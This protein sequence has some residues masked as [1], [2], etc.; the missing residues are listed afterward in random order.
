MF[1]YRKQISGCLETKELG[2]WITKG[3]METFGDNGNVH[4]L[5]YDNCFRGIY[6]CQTHQNVYFKYVQF[7]VYHL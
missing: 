5:D 4:Y 3:Y 1:S 2:E 7:N 6:R